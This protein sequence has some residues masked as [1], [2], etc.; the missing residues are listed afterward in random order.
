MA[1]VPSR[2]SELAAAV[3][4]DAPAVRRRLRADPPTRPSEYALALDAAVE[5]G[6]LAA[7]VALVDHYERR[8]HDVPW[9]RLVR[10]P[11]ERAFAA[12]HAAVGEWLVLRLIVARQ[13]ERDVLAPLRGSLCGAIGSRGFSGAFAGAAWVLR[14]RDQQAPPAARMLDAPHLAAVVAATET[15]LRAGR[16]RC[17]AWLALIFGGDA[18]FARAVRGFDGFPA[19]VRAVLEAGAE[20]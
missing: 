18:R 17:A 8:G 19:D 6:Q 11:I 3:R 12:G 14:M 2:F 9:A 16:P 10:Q 15:A 4:A 20:S 1:F 13:V 7:L 5:T